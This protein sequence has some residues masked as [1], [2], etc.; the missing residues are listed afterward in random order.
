MKKKISNFINNYYLYFF[1]IILIIIISILLLFIITYSIIKF[2]NFKKNTLD[3]ILNDYTNNSKNILNLYGDYKIINIY[4]MKKP[5]TKPIL[6]LFN[7]FSLYKYNS[8]LHNT[9]IFELKL[10]NNKH[11]F[12]FLEKSNTVNLSDKIV[13]LNNDKLKKIHIKKYNY[14]INSI[15]NDTKKRVG[16]KNF[17]NWK[18]YKNNCKDFVKEILKT[19][20]FY[21]KSNK[22]FIYSDLNNKILKKIVKT[23]YLLYHATIISNNLFNIIQKY[24]FQCILIN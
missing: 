17:F 16:Y 5:L 8:P 15:L 23:N 19:I 14:S 24:I 22:N 4:L 2:F 21:N 11:K 7:L 12:I 1:I 10:S 13:I 3:L 9:I 20:K 6:F 18:L